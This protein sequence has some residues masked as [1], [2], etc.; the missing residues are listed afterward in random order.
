MF[1]KSQMCKSLSIPNID[2]QE[3]SGIPFR[4]KHSHMCSCNNY[5]VK[6]LLFCF[7]QQYF[8]V[9]DK[10][11]N[12][13]S[14]ITEYMHLLEF[15]VVIHHFAFVAVSGMIGQSLLSPSE[16]FSC[17]MLFYC[18]PGKFEPASCISLECFILEYKYPRFVL[19]GILNRF[20]LRY[21]VHKC[22][23]KVDWQNSGWY[24]AFRISKHMGSA[25]VLLDIRVP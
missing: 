22:K 25:N 14:I 11:Y 13:W 9:H 5:W 21:I 8:S 23:I 12:D 6:A 16:L 17:Y 1:V 2:G 24:Y 18:W 19:T 20:H 10:G 3:E 15:G 7:H 4:R